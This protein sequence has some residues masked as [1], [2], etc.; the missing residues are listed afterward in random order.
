MTEIQVASFNVAW[1]LS[2]PT[3][4]S[5]SEASLGFAETSPLVV[6]LTFKCCG[7]WRSTVELRGKR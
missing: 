2:A 7:A 6:S 4:L 1:P 5:T 3:H